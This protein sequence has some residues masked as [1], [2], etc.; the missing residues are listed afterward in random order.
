MQHSDTEVKMSDKYLTAKQ[1]AAQL[2]VNRT[3]LHRWE[4]KGLIES[5]KIGGVK[6]FPPNTIEKAK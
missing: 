1:L 6:R 4:K 2:Q 3:T 5:V